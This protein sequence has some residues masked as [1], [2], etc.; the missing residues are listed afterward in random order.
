MMATLSADQRNKIHPYKFILLI[1][2]GSIVM[3]FAGFTSAYVVKSNQSNWLQFSMPPVFWY[4]TIV[5][6]ASSL[7]IYLAE[8]AF[9]ARE[10][11][12]YRTLI[13]VT[14]FL[15]VVF[16]VLQWLGFKYLEDHGVQILGSGSNPS[17]SFIGV[18]TGV[19]MLHV[20]GGVV[21][22]LIMFFRAFSSRSKSYSVIP[23]N[24]MNIY[25]HFVDGLWLYLFTF[26][27][28]VSA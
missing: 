13:T 16:M 18:I 20:L 25:W 17:A 21:A 2:M 3:M 19:H 1:A 10:M 15:G 28:Y 27:L 7:T 24:M 14:A 9:K 12:R 8:K 22:L 5:I 11:S 26:F 6:L 4:S 23:I